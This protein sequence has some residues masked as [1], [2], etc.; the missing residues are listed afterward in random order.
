MLE[1]NEKQLKVLGEGLLSSDLSLKEGLVNTHLSEEIEEDLNI[2]E[3]RLRNGG[4]ERC[5]GVGNG[6]IGLTL[7]PMETVMIV[8][9][10]KNRRC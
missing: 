2:L 5:G 9:K 8:K 4:I 3:D 6:L 10:R 1:L 7:I